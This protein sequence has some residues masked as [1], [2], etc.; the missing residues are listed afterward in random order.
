MVCLGGV[1]VS[2]IFG[3]GVGVDLLEFSDRRGHMFGPMLLPCKLDGD[4]DG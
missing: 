4:E 2:L 1:G 3:Y